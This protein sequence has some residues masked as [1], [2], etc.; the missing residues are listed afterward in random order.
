MARKLSTRLDAIE[1]AAATSALTDPAKILLIQILARRDALFWP[2][3]WSISKQPPIP[4]LRRRQQE[5]LAGIAGVSARADGRSQWKTVHELR[6]RL[7]A[8]GMLRTVG[9]NGET[10]SVILTATGESTARCLVGDRLAGH[11]DAAVAL[12]VLKAMV[13]KHGS[14]VRES[15]L[16][17]LPCIGN[18]EDWNDRTEL[19]LP[20]LTTGIAEA[21]S[22]TQG[23]ILFTV[24]DGAELPEPVAVD[25]APEADLDAVYLTAFHSERG[26]L[27]T[28]EPRDPSEIFVPKSASLYWPQEEKV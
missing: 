20:L 12:A 25:I 17:N 7:V 14:P 15:V 23:R 27:A 24:V 5:Y 13:E 16:F 6:Q 21:H 28:V 8:A 4:E 10:V 3:R 26:H 22:D 19:F 18:P 1:Q 9:A 11:A 2:W